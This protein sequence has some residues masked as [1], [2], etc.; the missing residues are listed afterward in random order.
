MGFPRAPLPEDFREKWEEL[1][2]DG[3]LTRHYGGK[4][5]KIVRWREES[6]LPQQRRTRSTP[7]GFRKAWA[8]GLT[9]RELGARFSASVA[10]VARWRAET[11]LRRNVRGKVCKL[12]PRTYAAG[13]RCPR[14][15]NDNRLVNQRLR[16]D[17]QRQTLENGGIAPVS[18]HNAG[19]YSNWGCRCMECIEAKSVANA[20]QKQ[21][22]R[23]G[24]PSLQAAPRHWQLAHS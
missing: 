16:E 11:G 18:S 1:K 20:T 4:S 21:R 15:R 12:P 17:R 10:V 24:T 6:G 9:D 2:T 22:Q 3:A 8:L 23:A 7:R 5:D 13:C 19:T 14:C